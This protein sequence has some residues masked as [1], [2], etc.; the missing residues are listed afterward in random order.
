LALIDG[1]VYPAILISIIQRIYL[2]PDTSSCRREGSPAAT[3][4]EKPTVAVQETQ[5]EHM[6]PCE[7][8]ERV[9]INEK[10]VEIYIPHYLRTEIV[11]TALSAY[12][13]ADGSQL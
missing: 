11:Q 7:I 5:C 2:G 12:A 10:V 13:Q 3:D 6:I 1:Y 8:V 4:I 9:A